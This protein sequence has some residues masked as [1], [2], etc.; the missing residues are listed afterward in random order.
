MTVHISLDDTLGEA[1]VLAPRSEQTLEM[2]ALPPV[3]IG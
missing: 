2:P 1:E 3:T